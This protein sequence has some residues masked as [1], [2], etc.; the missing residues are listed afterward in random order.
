MGSDTSGAGSD[1]VRCFTDICRDSRRATTECFCAI[2][3]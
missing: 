1:D 2:G 3:D